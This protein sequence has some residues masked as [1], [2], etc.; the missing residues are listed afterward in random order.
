MIA[1]APLFVGGVTAAIAIQTGI[2]QQIKI[3]D[4]Y[5]L[6]HLMIAYWFLFIFP[7]PADIQLAIWPPTEDTQD[8]Q[9][10]PQ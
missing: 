4:P 9:M 8:L 6:H 3:A 7:S 5:Y 1:L 2:W 10:N